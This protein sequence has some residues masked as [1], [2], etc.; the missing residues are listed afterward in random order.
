MKRILIYTNR[1]IDPIYWDASTA[2]LEAG[3]YLALFKHLDE[4]WKVYLDL[5]E[6]LEPLV[7]PVDHV[8]GCR[9]DRCLSAPLRLKERAN[10]EELRKKHLALY[11]KAK[12]GDALAAR[13]LLRA[14]GSGEYQSYSFAE[15]QSASVE[16][17]VARINAGH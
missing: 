16:F 14:R 1:K 6:E 4:G 3:A 2:E 9:C 8:S 7:F 10:M 5:Q 17:E 15:V 11:E 12:K 13:A